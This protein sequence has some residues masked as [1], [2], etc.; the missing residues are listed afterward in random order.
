MNPGI[1]VL[2]CDSTISSIEGID[3]LARMRGSDMEEYVENLTNRAMNGE[4]PLEAVYA[5]RMEQIRPTRSECV[6]VGK[7]YLERLAVGVKGALGALQD[8]GWRV[9]LVSGGLDVCL[10][11]LKQHLEAERLYAV[12]VEFDE[13]GAYAGFDE[14]YPTAHSGGKC[15]IIRRIREEYPGKPVVMV[16]DGMSDAETDVVAHMFIAYTG[17]VRR[18]AVI[19]RARHQVASF[20]ALEELLLH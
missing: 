12:P 18:P 16:G 1:L 11:P 9:F 7:L 15:R 2:D 13:H 17:F 20:S 6:A 19:A 14:Q 10:E 3:E 5:K 4:L 8:A